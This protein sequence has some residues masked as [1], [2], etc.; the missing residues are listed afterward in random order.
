M[1]AVQL[2]KL[3]TAKRLEYVKNGRRYVHDFPAGVE[4][5]YL[6]AGRALVIAPA[7][8]EGGKWISDKPG[9]RRAKRTTKRPAKRRAKRTTKRK[10]G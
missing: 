5:G 4:L 6:E 9:K 10:G 7:S 8:L 1:T 2:K 3:G